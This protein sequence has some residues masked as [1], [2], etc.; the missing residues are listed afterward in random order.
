MNWNIIWI[1]LNFYGLEKV[2]AFIR[3]IIYISIFKKFFIF[4]L[5][6]FISLFFYLLEYIYLYI[7]YHL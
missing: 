3:E 2:E 5:Y 4:F 1:E 6:S 7:K